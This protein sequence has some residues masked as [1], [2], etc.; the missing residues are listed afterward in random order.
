[1]FLPPD[2]ETLLAGKIDLSPRNIT[3]KLLDESVIHS[4]L[5]DT[6]PTEREPSSKTCLSGA[7]TRKGSCQK[8]F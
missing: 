8:D 6:H 2:G 4:H 1:M 7:T 3:I 5:M